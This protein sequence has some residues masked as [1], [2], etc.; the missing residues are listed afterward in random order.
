MTVSI[1][2]VGFKVLDLFRHI[3]LQAAAPHRG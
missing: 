2:G 3:V 1:K